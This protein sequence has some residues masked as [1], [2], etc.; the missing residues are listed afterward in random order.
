MKPLNITA[1][2]MEIMQVVWNS[3]GTVTSSEIMAALPGKKLTTIVTLAGRLIEK[4]VLASEKVGR[5]HAHQ[6]SALISEKE[7]KKIQTRN[8]L[9]TVHKGS[10]KSLLSA[11]FDGDGLTAADL[12]ELKDYMKKKGE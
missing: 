12:K 8:F 11:L 4:G 5:S 9:S 1:A 7:Y 6:Y 2:E 3:E 10:A